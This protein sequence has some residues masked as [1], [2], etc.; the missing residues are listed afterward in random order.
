MSDEPTGATPDL[1]SHGR[2]ETPDQRSDRNWNE[3]LQ[4][5]RVMQTGVQ[6]LTGFLLILPFQ[7]RFAEL[8][9]YQHVVYLVLVLVCIA[10]TGLLVAPVAL[11]RALFRK[12]RKRSVV[13]G[14]D[15]MTRAGLVLLAIALAGT[16]LLVFDVVVG[17]TAGIV[18]GSIAA[19]V[20]LGLW[21]VVPA[22]V[23]RRA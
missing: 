8:D 13:T 23:H 9:T 6:I 17:R 7:S 19:V 1:R 4:E 10:T 22:I 12:H 21:A 11:H 5:L 2:P 18:V 3:L 20:L 16:A 14:G 15:R